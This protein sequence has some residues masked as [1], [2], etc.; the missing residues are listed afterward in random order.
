MSARKK[1]TGLC[2][3]H[4]PYGLADQP[5][6]ATQVSCA[7]GVWNVEPQQSAEDDSDGSGEGNGE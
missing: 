4:F 1:K 2:A 6:D 5:K 3:E 7:H